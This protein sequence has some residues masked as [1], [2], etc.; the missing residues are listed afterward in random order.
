MDLTFIIPTRI[1]SED[2]LRN[3]IA[4]VSYILKHTDAKVIVK[5]VSSHNTFLFRALPL[6]KKYVD[7]TNLKH[8]FEES[9]DK[10]FCKSKVLN[11]LIVESDLS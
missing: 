11:D 2:R 9:N 8:I 3:I 4:S 1:E 7:T 6:I 10:L 5:E